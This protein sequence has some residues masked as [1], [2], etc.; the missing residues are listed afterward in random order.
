MASLLGQA[1]G[2][3][4]QGKMTYD[5]RRPR[6]HGL[7]ERIKGSHR[8]KIT[9]FG[10]RTALFFTRTHTR[11]FRP[12]LADAMSVGGATLARPFRK[13]AEAMDQWVQQTALAV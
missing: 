10:L 2:S 8:Y 9:G 3:V 13:L 7:I 11:L 12:G 6:L 1:N 4:I 5:R